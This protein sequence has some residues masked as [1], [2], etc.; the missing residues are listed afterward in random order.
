MRFFAR[1]RVGEIVARL[2]NDMVEVQGI[3]VDVPLAFVTSVV[4]LGIASAILD[5]DVVVPL[6]HR[7]RARSTGRA[8][9]V[10]HAGRHHPDEP[11]AAGEE[12]RG[13]DAHHRHLHGDTAG[14]RERDGRAGAAAVRAGE[15][16]AGRL[17]PPVPDGLLPVAR[18]PLLRPGVLRHPCPAVRR[19]HG[20]RRGD[21]RRNPGRVHRV[22]GPGDLADPESAGTVR[23]PAEGEGVAGAGVRVLRRAGGGGRRGGGGVQ[24]ESR[25]GS[26]STE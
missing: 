17:G 15:P 26:S 4:R 19:L 13:R 24:R 20:P 12:R 2:N 7:Q 23:R 3:L 1:T 21:H 10:A 9:P 6:P 8:G 5:L 22:P 11:G 18:H 16:V 25:R 14:S